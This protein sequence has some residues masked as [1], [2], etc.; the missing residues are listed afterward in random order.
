MVS[1]KE[2]NKKAEAGCANY[3]VREGDRAVVT[4]ADSK[5]KVL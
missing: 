5:A 4:C 2:M 3:F 1:G